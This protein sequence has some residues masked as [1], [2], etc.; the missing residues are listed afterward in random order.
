MKSPLM[1]ISL[2]L[3]VSVGCSGTTETDTDEPV[4][5]TAAD[6][7][8]WYV[9]ADGD[10]SGSA[11]GTET[12]CDAPAGYVA[13]DDDCDDDN[14]AVNPSATE[15]CDTIDNNCDDVV[16][17]DA[18]DAGS[19]Y[20]DV[21][22]DS[23][24]DDASV[25]TACDQPTDTIA[26]GGDCDDAD[27][28]IN[29]GAT[30]YCD[31]ADGDC[32]GTVDDSC[33]SAGDG[34]T[35]ALAL[36]VDSDDWSVTGTDV[37]VDWS[38]DLHM[39]ETTTCNDGS[40]SG[41]GPELVLSV[42]LV[43]GDE[44]NFSEHGGVDVLLH[45]QK[46]C[47]DT[48]ACES[49]FDFGET[50]GVD[51]VATV[52]ETITLI[53]EAYDTTPTSPDYDVRVKITPLD[54]GDGIIT[55]T[56]QCDTGA[57]G[58]D[59]GCTDTCQLE[60]GFGCIGEPSV[61]GSAP[62]NS[63]CATAIALV[64]GAT[65][66]G[67][68]T[69]AT[70]D[71]STGCGLSTGNGEVVYTIDV[72]DGYDVNIEAV[73][74]SG[75]D[76]ALAIAA[77]CTDMDADTCIDD[78]DPGGSGDTETLKHSNSSGSTE[79]I[80]VVVDG[81]APGGTYDLTATTSPT[82]APGAND[83]CATPIALT[84][85]VQVSG[86]NSTAASDYGSACGVSDGEELVY[87]IDVPDGQILSVVADPAAG[88]DLVLALAAGCTELEADTC[89]GDRDSAGS[90]SA[91]SMS[92]SNTSGSTETIYIVVDTWSN[93]GLFDLVATV[94][95]PPSNDTCATPET[96][97]SGVQVTGN[98]SLA[99]SDYGTGCGISTGNDLIYSIDV[100]AGDRLTAVATPESG[101]DLA[102]AIGGSCSL[103]EAD[104]CIDEEDSGFD[105]TAE[106]IVYNNVTGSTETIFI[107]V[108]T[109]SGAGTFDLVGT[110]TTP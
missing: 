43:A 107:V 12:D 106:T 79:T 70:N 41:D 75:F 77:S 87:T 4:E 3:A 19:W 8:T 72:Q 36:P 74:D 34:T 6:E 16:D 98:T 73:P 2:A 102:L 39:T 82:P 13:S 38:N 54:C 23:Y 105:G 80:Y 33:T 35:C 28:D 89:I 68:T 67:D 46:T 1:L 99:S 64:D 29:P 60:A 53:V 40:S 78:V 69:Y 55:G 71:Y 45:V 101:F 95:A 44:L 61:C 88:Y 63:T 49:S 37:M 20:P 30:E 15:I 100:P 48:M 83:T 84:S 24:G 62:A 9:D 18:T 31:G 17:T 66:A 22:G 108:D 51:Y 11:L 104:T 90:G 47:D 86:D 58:T 93:P 91:E 96:L 109:W 92:Y 50:S 81:F 10:G 76:V 110:I 21:D 94:E 65:T 32:N 25:T 97:T 59:D 26:T 42:D 52:D 103:I 14:D 85:G 7:V 57:T 5:C 56:E 27:A